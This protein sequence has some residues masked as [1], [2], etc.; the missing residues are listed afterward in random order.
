MPNRPDFFQ[1]AS[2]KATSPASLPPAGISVQAIAVNPPTINYLL[3]GPAQHLTV[4]FTPSNATNK[5]VIWSVATG[6]KVVVTPTGPSTA[7][8]TAASG[9][10]VTDLAGPVTATSQ[11][12]GKTAVCNVTFTNT[13]VAVTGVLLDHSALAL[14]MGESPQLLV[15]TVNPSNA[16]DL[17]VIWTSNSPAVATVDTHGNVTPV[18]VGTATIKAASESDGTKFAVCTVTVTDTPVTAV[19]LDH[20]TLSIAPSGNASLTAT[21]TPSGASDST[22]IWTSDNST[23]TLTN[24]THTGDNSTIMVNV[25]SLALGTSFHVTAT[26]HEAPGKNA[27]STVTVG[28]EATVITINQSSMG[29][30]LNESAT[31]TATVSPSGAPIKWSIVGSSTVATVGASTGTVTAGGSAGSVQ[32]I[33][34]SLDGTVASPACT[35]TVYDLNST[36]TPVPMVGGG[37][38]G[39]GTL[40]LSGA[41]MAVDPSNGTVYIAYVDSSGVGFVQK[42]AQGASSWTRVGGNFAASSVPISASRAQNLSLAINQGIPYVAYLESGSG[43]FSQVKK[44]DSTNNW[45]TL[46]GTFVS[47]GAASYLSLAFDSSN[48]PFL[49]EV[50]AGNSGSVSVYRLTGGSWGSIGSGSIGFSNAASTY[51][52]VGFDSTGLLAGAGDASCI[53]ALNNAGSDVRAA[54][55]P[56][57]AVFISIVGQ[58]GNFIDMAIQRGTLYIGYQSSA[59]QGAVFIQQPTGTTAIHSMGTTRADYTSIAVDPRNGTTYLAYADSTGSPFVNISKLDGSAAS[60]TS[61]TVIMNLGDFFVN[62][63]KT[64]FYV[65]SGGHGHLYV[66]YGVS[67]PGGVLVK[68]FLR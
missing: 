35:V 3:T 11:D 40:N 26:S 58:P 27:T 61:G 14:T 7:D 2:L 21:I 48:A 39:S 50:D 5:T 33:A 53:V 54:D 25:N 64:A 56:G 28:T 44:F 19:V 42:A 62:A 36:T 43:N 66:C 13:A 22:I 55:F 1:L 9:A 30:G 41:T 16:T 49:G 67:S 10:V 29:L 4:S 37:V 65:D 31:L 38:L 15:A 8:V 32:I 46:A 34:Q 63:I 20:S 17:N 52:S 24:P 59:G 6:S 47:V 60:G 12:G 23:A 18:G 57:P 68:D 51:T 45:V